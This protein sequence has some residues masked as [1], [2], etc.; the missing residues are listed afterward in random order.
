[1][2]NKLELVEHIAAATDTSK[3]ASAA[4][5]DASRWIW[6][7]LGQEARRRQGAQSRHRRGDQNPRLEERALQIRRD[8]ESRPQQKVSAKDGWRARLGR[9]VF[10]RRG[11]WLSAEFFA[12]AGACLGP[13]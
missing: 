5:L 13:A 12:E 3:A 10:R 11:L 2:V 1:M 7:F 9:A 4:A 6:H 8:A